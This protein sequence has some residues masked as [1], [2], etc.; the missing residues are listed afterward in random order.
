MSGSDETLLSDLIVADHSEE[1]D[2][3]RPRLL[4]GCAACRAC[5][6]WSLKAAPP[7]SSI[8]G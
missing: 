5:A 8:K 2:R 6:L 4:E 7:A 3:V 1:M